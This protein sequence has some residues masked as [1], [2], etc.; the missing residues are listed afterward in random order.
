MVDHDSGRLVWAAEGHDAAT[1]GVFFALLGPRRCQLITQV[2][3]DAAEWIAKAVAVHCPAAV[4][5][6]DPFHVV[7]VGSAIIENVSD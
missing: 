5:C 2:S 7:T 4:R 1:L 3:A 6:A